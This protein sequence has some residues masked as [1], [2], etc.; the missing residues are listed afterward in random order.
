MKKLLATG[1]ILCLMS[2][3]PMADTFAYSISSARR[4]ARFLTDRMAYEMNLTED[5]Y[6]DIYEVNFDFIYRVSNIMP[7]VIRNRDRAINQY[8]NFL[9]VRNDDLRWILSDMQYNIFTDIDYFFR[10]I[11]IMR[12]NWSFRVYSFYSD[13]S[14]FY[15]RGGYFPRNYK[16]NGRHYRSFFNNESYYRKHYKS[17]DNRDRRGSFGPQESGRNRF[18]NRKDY[19]RE[20]LERDGMRRYNSRGEF[21]HQNNQRDYDNREKFNDN[22]HRNNNRWNKK[23]DNSNQ[24]NTRNDRGSNSGISIST[25][26]SE[27]MLKDDDKS[28]SQDRS[29]KLINNNRGRR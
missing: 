8:Y 27:R 26:E 16:Y 18:D 9:N 23:S 11:Y 25:R 20:F 19:H 15:F 21:D 3:M 2:M 6:D 4:D 13:R 17:F 29:T 22:N 28:K 1:F 24:F 7:D 10:P 14:I 5:Q 12:G